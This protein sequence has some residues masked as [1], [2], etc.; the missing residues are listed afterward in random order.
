LHR[1][2]KSLGVSPSRGGEEDI[3]EVVEE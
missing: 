2:L 1:K 3:E